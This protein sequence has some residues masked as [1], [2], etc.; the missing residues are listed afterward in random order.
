M[1]LSLL[2]A[3]Q[4]ASMMLLAGFGACRGKLLPEDAGK[5]TSAIC[6]YILCSAIL[7]SAFQMEFSHEKLI[8]FLIGLLCAACINALFIGLSIVFRNL[9]HFVDVDRLSLI[10]VNSG[11]LIVPLI[12]AMLGQEFVFYSSSYPALMNC[13]FWTHGF[14]ILSGD[15]TVPLRKILVNPNLI[16]ICVGMLFFIFQIPL[17]GILSLTISRLADCIGPVSMIGISIVMGGLNLRK[18]FTNRRAWLLTFLRLIFLPTVCIFLIFLIRPSRFYPGAEHVLLASMLA[19]S[20]PS[21]VMVSQL[22]SLTGRGTDV[23]SAVNVLSTLLCVITM[24][25][26]IIIYQI[27]CIV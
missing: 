9:F 12:S 21:A 20:A 17:P 22:A 14:R 25:V 4:I 27:L 18:A 24:P 7:F 3:R 1:E 6:L 23:A 2:I 26:I 8:L 10:Y 19:A 13:L 11:N 5:A 16:A 15:K